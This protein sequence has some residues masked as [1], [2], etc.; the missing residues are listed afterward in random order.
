MPAASAVATDDVSL[1]AGMKY[2]MAAHPAGL[3]AIARHLRTGLAHVAVGSAAV[4]I[5][6]SSTAPALAV[7]VR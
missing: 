4:G 6:Q 5:V 7:P 3:I 2:D 1:A